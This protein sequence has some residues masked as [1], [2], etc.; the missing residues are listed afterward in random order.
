MKRFATLVVIAMAL[1]ATSAF[2]VNREKQAYLL[3]EVL[4]LS[5]EGVPDRLIAKQIEAMDFAFELTA[6]D[7]VELRTLGVSDEVIEVLIDTS[8]RKREEDQNVYVRV[9]AGY[10]SPWYQFPYAWGFYY[11]PFPDWYSF[12][13]YPFHYSTHHFGWYGWCGNSYYYAYNGYTQPYAYHDRDYR[14]YRSRD[15]DDGYRVAGHVRSDVASVPVR[16]VRE[17]PAGSGVAPAAQVRDRDRTPDTRTRT[18]A[19]RVARPTIQAPR[20]PYRAD[21]VTSPP[22]R[23]Q[24]GSQRTGRTLDALRA[25]VVTPDAPAGTPAQPAVREAEA[26][27]PT[28][29]QREAAPR[30]LDRRPATPPAVRQGESSAPT[31]R[32]DVA[33]PRLPD[34]RAVEPRTVR[35]IDHAPRVGSAPQRF[36]PPSAPSVRSQPASSVGGRGHAGSAATAPARGISRGKVGR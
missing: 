13:Y 29:R 21:R 34:R 9:S 27:R 6:D 25:P 17:V 35:Q 8:L 16:A 14:R 18:I 31:V 4:R 15:R 32:R 12:Y 20:T 22:P 33:A 1:L 19:T 10:Y 28:E 36:A 7:I 26:S 24:T 5:H 30:L 2:A 11:D 23:R 3:D